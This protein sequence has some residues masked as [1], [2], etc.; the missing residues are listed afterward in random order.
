[1]LQGK[2]APA[3][4]PGRSLVRPQAPMGDLLRAGGDTRPSRESLWKISCVPQFTVNASRLDPYK[5]F[6]F[7]IVWD[8]RAVAGVSRI[9]PLVRRTEV[10]EHREGGDLS[11]A[12]RSPGLTSFDP[13]V[14]ER[15]VTHDQE[16]EDWAAMTYS[17]GA[18]LGSEVSLASF[19]KDIRIEVMNEA[20]QIVKA[21][22]VYR[23][24]VSE[25]QALP[26]LDANSS[27]VAIESITIQ[28][29]GWQRDV[30]IKEPQEPS[31]A[32]K[33]RSGK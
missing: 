7:R 28:N 2:S 18:P 32:P 15:G 4:S 26:E 29:E 33:K 11:S 14:I 12:H 13:I 22:N 9:S 30:E 16:F 8:G 21:Y 6:K 5:G 27:E 10:L 23:C 24:W 3:W 1:M 17:Y 25:Y 19:R 31:D 20:G